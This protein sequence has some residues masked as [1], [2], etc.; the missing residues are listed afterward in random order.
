[1]IP[2]LAEKNDLLRVPHTMHDACRLHLPLGKVG[3][4]CA[5][6]SLKGPTLGHGGGLCCSI[7]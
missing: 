2:V 6:R 1:M 4:A 5:H 7:H 3:E